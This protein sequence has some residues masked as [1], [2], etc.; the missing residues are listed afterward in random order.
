MGG[1]WDEDGRDMAY[2][3]VGDSRLSKDKLLGLMTIP[4]SDFELLFSVEI[5]VGLSIGFVNVNI[6][7]PTNVVVNGELVRSLSLS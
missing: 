7:D 2:D 5:F 3:Q 4:M 6:D 1:D